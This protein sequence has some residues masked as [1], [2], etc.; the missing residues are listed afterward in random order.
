MRSYARYNRGLARQYDG[1]MIAMHYAKQTQQTYR[2]VIRRYVEFAKH[3]SIA[4]ATHTDIRHF[5]TYISEHGATLGTVYQ[6]LTVLRLFYDFLNLGGVVS[7]VAPRFVRLR[8][9]WQNSLH[10]LTESQIERLISVTRTLRERALV[11]FFYSTGCRLSEVLHLKIEDIDFATRIV[12]LR[13]KFGK[14]RIAILTQSTARAISAYLA[15]RRH[16]V[17]FQSD[18]PAQKGFLVAHDGVKWI[19]TWGEYSGPG[20]TRVT[21]RKYLGTLHDLTYEMAMKK[22]RA[23]LAGRNL[24]RPAKNRF[25][26]KVAVQQLVKRIASRA[27]IRNVSPHTFRRT[28][29]THLYDHG[30]NIEV[31]RA[32]LGHV[33]IQTTLRYAHLGPDRLTKTFERCHPRAKLKG[34]ASGLVRTE[35]AR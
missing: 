13:G 22:H 15:G 11:E 14:V 27:G 7:Y 35:A 25:L 18:Q 24:T 20:G 30:A 6:N 5:I 33:W 8:R 28:F 26:S 12:R 31:I 23:N 1:W 3:R 19:S 29:A 34:R 17:V 10:P 2:K 32:L 9:P 16:G 4:N 21:K